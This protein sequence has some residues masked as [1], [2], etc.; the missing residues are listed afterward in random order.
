MPV[1]LENLS[2]SYGNRSIFSDLQLEI[3]DN[4]MI[5]VTGESGSGKSTLLNIIGLLEPFGEGKLIF[6]NYVNPMMNGF[7]ATRLRRNKIGYLFQNYALA[8]NLTVE[9]NLKFALAYQRQINKRS[10]IREALSAVFLPEAIL[11]Q[12]VYQLSG[13]E[14]QRVAIARLFL[15]PCKIVLADEPTGSLDRKNRDVVIKL[16]HGLHEQGKTVIIVTH[17]DIVADSCDRKVRIVNADLKEI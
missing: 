3:Q 5:A 16:L 7:A 4:D 11:H 9:Q 12:K 8:E 15:K 14:Q 6:D 17:D 10:A 2:K 13:G 1:H